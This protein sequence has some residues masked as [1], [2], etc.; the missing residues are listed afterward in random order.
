MNKR[1]KI[2]EVAAKAIFFATT[3]AP[4]ILLTCTT[5]AAFALDT[6]KMP[7]DV[8]GKIMKADA[9]ANA[10]HT[11]VSYMESWSPMIVGGLGLTLVGYDFAKNRSVD[12]AILG[13]LGVG[14]LS[15]AFNYI[16]S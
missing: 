11:L 16:F 5:S 4:L 2:K 15:L 10:A 1:Q 7:A 6:S 8:Q 3:A 9:A 13:I 12:R 14:I